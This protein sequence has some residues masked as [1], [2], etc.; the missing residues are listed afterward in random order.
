MVGISTVGRAKY[1][2]IAYEDGDREDITLAE[3]KQIVVPIAA[4]RKF[5][6]PRGRPKKSAAPKYE[7]AAGPSSNHK[8]PVGNKGYSTEQGAAHDAAPHKRSRHEQPVREMEESEEPEDESEDEDGFDLGRASLPSQRPA[9]QRFKMNKN[10]GASGDA[11]PPSLPAP[12]SSSAAIFGNMAFISD[13]SFVAD[14]QGEDVIDSP[15]WAYVNEAKRV[16]EQLDAVLEGLGLGR[17]ALINVSVKLKDAGIGWQPFVGVWNAWIG[18][19][20]PPVSSL[21]PLLRTL[22]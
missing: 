10:R 12:L 14:L 9:I 18:R 16:L 1:A 20:E 3:L 21:R 8:P 5:A 13:I 2:N 19:V 22:L 17:D 7:S 4:A 6:A 15:D 11:H